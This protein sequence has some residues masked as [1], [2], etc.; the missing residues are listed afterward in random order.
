MKLNADGEPSISSG[1]DGSPYYLEAEINSPLC[2]LRS[3]ES[4][5]FETEWF[6][7]RAESEFH[8][9]TDAGIVVR[10]LRATRLENAKIRLS[11]SFGVFFAGRLVAHFYD[12]HGLSL[13]NLTI[14]TVDPIE[15]V[16][17]ETEIVPPGKAARISLHL[18][19]GNGLDRGSLQD[20]QVGTGENR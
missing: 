2:Q 9:A 6:P 3:G 7:T 17:L 14:A 15:P 12:E 8:G 19:D 11:G 10:P 20:V 4:C 13:G 5:D 18:E 1:G 16:S